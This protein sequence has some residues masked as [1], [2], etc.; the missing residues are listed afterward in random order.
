MKKR[1][2]VF[3][4]IIFIILL[5]VIL[6]VFKSNNLKYDLKINN[7]KIHITEKYTKTSKYIEINTGKNIYP[8]EYINVPK[9]N[10]KIVNNIYYYNND[11]IEC[12]LPILNNEIITDVMCFVDNIIYDY[13]EI[14]GEYPDIDKF[15]KSIN[16]YKIRNKDYNDYKYKKISTIKYNLDTINKNVVITT[17]RGLLI[18]GE[19][20]DLFSNDIYSNEISTF[21]GDYYLTADYNTQ[22]SF[23][24]FYLVNLKSKEIVKLKSKNDI[25]FDSY[26]Q[27]IVDN[28]IYLYDKD[29]E[30]QYEIDINNKKINIVS[31]GD[32]VKFYINHKWE[33]INKTKANKE[34]YF[35]YSSLDNKFSRYDVVKENDY[36]YYLLKK[37]GILYKLYRVDKNNI[38][39]YKYIMNIPVTD[40]IINDNYIYYVYKNKLYYYSDDIGK[41][42]L[43]ENSELEFNNLIKYYIY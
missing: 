4:L 31:S 14:S 18:N 12:I 20:I 40:F 36:Y 41:K 24:I 22:Y 43:L 27:G 19:K 26:I 30:I 6:N 42:I 34:M 32:H 38:N 25:S 3:L 23:N 35:D 17:Y 16:L 39:I 1:L 13:T 8:V 5:I 33:K 7:K 15:V 10:K 11:S 37:D 2:N 28:K 21:L 9:N 29:N